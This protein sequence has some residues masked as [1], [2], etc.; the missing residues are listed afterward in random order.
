M[1]LLQAFCSVLFMQI[2]SLKGTSQ[3]LSHYEWRDNFIHH[4]LKWMN[5]D[6]VINCQNFFSISFG[7]KSL[8]STDIRLS[9]DSHLQLNTAASPIQV[10]SPIGC[11]AK[12]QSPGW[13]SLTCVIRKL[14][15]HAQQS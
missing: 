4:I 13:S 6:G 7:Y 15:K 5:E 1:F 11:Q 8:S 12:M 14:G 2:C 9:V 3:N 10:S